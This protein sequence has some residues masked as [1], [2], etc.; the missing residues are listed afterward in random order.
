MHILLTHELVRPNRKLNAGHHT[1][2]TTDCPT[3]H[4]TPHHHVKA[5]AFLFVPVRCHGE[6][7]SSKFVL[8][9]GNMTHVSQL[10]LDL[11]RSKYTQRTTLLI[12]TQLHV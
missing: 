3:L 8:M 11:M 10:M 5:K 4:A 12:A 1:G 7:G 6:T 9:T 2:Y